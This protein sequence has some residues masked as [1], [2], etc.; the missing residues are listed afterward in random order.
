[1]KLPLRAGLRRG[2]E[3]TATSWDITVPSPGA[4]LRLKR[5][6][7]FTE[8]E[9]QT[10][11]SRRNAGINAITQFVAEAGVDHTSSYTVEMDPL[12]AQPI[13]RFGTTYIV[14]SPGALLGCAGAPSQL[15]GNWQSRM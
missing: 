12:H 13:V 9:L 15:P 6:V 4:L 3:P 11:L 5:C 10:L 2:T 7:T 8:A 1:M 14:A